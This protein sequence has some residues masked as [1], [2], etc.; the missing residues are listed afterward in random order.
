MRLETLYLACLSL[1]SIALA[2][3]IPTSKVARQAAG[4]NPS[5]RLPTEFNVLNFT[6]QSLDGGETLASFDF[7]Y[8]EKTNN[9]TTQCHFNS[10]SPGAG[11]PGR[12][13]RF[14]CDNKSTQF[15]YQNQ[16]LTLIQAICPDANG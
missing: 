8:L 6:G 4:C 3:T 13:P 12:T 11:P 15:I 1:A 9:V 7:G 14:A 5:E 2:R 10:S 16:R